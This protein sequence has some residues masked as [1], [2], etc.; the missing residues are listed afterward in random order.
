M[1]F[2]NLELIWLWISSFGV[3]F[4]FLS[5]MNE[6]KVFKNIPSYKKGLYSILLGTVI[7]FMLPYKIYIKRY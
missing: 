1:V 6:I 5:F 7:F 4:A 2:I 3:V